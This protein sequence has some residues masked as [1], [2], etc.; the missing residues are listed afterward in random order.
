MEGRGVGRDEGAARDFRCAAERECVC[1]CV[2]VFAVC[3]ICAAHVYMCVCVCVYLPQ[4]AAKVERERGGGEEK[5]RRLSR[6]SARRSLPLLWVRP[7]RGRS[8]AL[9]RIRQSDSE[10]A[11]R[12]GT[13]RKREREKTE[14]LW[15]VSFPFQFR[16]CVLSLSFSS[17]DSL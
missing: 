13:E 9:Q 1:A 14:F 3:A 6:F 17:R 7:L 8:G 2:C 4:N 15:L 16:S 10:R 5:G 11:Q 12:G